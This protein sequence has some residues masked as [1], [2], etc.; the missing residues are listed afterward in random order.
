[1]RISQLP[2]VDEHGVTIVADVND[3]WPRLIDAVDRVFSGPVQT[4][5]TRFLGCADCTTSEGA[6]AVGSTRPGFRVAAAVRG[7]ELALE[8]RHRFSRYALIFRLERLDSGESRLRAETRAAFPGL[9]GS[10]YRLLIIGTG[11][12][13]IVVRG[14]LS[15]VKHRSERAS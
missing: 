7:S 15:V 4:G 9:A 10:I 2:H 14:V 5:I 3:V 6:L 13:V 8:G 12:H 11:G 1:M